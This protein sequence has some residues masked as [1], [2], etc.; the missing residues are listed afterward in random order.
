MVVQD[1][2]GAAAHSDLFNVFFWSCVVVVIVSCGVVLHFFLLI[3][4]GA[5]QSLF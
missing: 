4:K 3:S 5:Q 2:L 1:W